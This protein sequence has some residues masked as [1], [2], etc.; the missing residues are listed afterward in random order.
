MEKE[1]SLHC[2]SP[3][4]GWRERVYPQLCFPTLR[5]ER[6]SVPPTVSPH[7]MGGGKE[8]TPN[9]VSP[10][11]GWGERVYP[12]LC[13]STL[14]V[15]GKSVPPTVFLHLTDGEKE[16]TPHCV[17]PPYGNSV[18]PTVFL[19]LTDGERVPLCSSLFLSRWGK[20]MG[21]MIFISLIM[22]EIFKCIPH[23]SL[24]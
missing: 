9:C 4:Y 5:M 19:N 6:K 22:V 3:P 2:V 21:G 18:P 14:W 24:S 1:C 20:T 15:E 7:L 8:C 23:S 17:S 12:P 11:Y 16:C 10:P 13:F